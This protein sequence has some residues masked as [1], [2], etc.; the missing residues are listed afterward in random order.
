M[1]VVAKE[2]TGFPRLGKR[3]SVPNV[4]LGATEVDRHFECN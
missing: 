4:S 2:V 3:A 1:E